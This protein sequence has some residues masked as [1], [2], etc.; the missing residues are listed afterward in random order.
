M[1]YRASPFITAKDAKRLAAHKQTRLCKFFAVG[2]CTKGSTCPFAH[3]TSHLRGLLADH[4]RKLRSRIPSFTVLPD[5]RMSRFWKHVSTDFTLRKF[6]GRYL[7]WA[8]RFLK[9]TTLYCSLALK[10]NMGYG[11]RAPVTPLIHSEEATMDAPVVLTVYTT[12]RWSPWD[13]AVLCIMGFCQ[14]FVELGHCA[15]GDSCILVVVL[16]RLWNPTMAWTFQ[17]LLYHFCL[18]QMFEILSF[19]T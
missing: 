16:R 3:G 19:G 13:G 9:D 10:W 2:A 11:L 15:Q 7:R 14:D 5:L 17:I 6:G 8:A 18:W 1:S 4:S 12:S